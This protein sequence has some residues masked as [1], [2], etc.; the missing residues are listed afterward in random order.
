MGK[1]V[2][3][4]YK[5]PQ[6]LALRRRAIARDGRRCVICGADVGRLGQS[7]VDHIL[8]RKTRPDLALRLDNLR[9]L[10]PSCD[11]KRHSEKGRDTVDRGPVGLDGYGETSG[12]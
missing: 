11:N 5:T 10:C 4:F 12:W 2:D 7:R 1:I 8:P 3:S 9:T 6:W